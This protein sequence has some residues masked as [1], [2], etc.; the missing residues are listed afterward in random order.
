MINIFVGP[1]TH[2]R[3]SRRCIHGPDGSGLRG[4]EAELTSG[5]AYVGVP[6]LTLPA[7][8]MEDGTLCPELDVS[9]TVRTG[10]P[11]I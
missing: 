10:N 5:K 3:I 6:R 9:T 8:F 7:R 1:L 4:R 2:S 11:V